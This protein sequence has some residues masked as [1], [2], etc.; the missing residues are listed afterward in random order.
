MKDE[1]TKKT[2]PCN[3]PSTSP[4]KRRKSAEPVTTRGHVTHLYI[5][6]PRYSAGRFKTA[7]G[8]EIT[9]SGKFMVAERDPLVLTGHWVQHPRDG[10]QFKVASF[11]FDDACKS[12]GRPGGSR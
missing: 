5:S 1:Q 12:V 8:L 7:E 4:Q 9:F 11:R 2:R 10:Q 3:G 6:E